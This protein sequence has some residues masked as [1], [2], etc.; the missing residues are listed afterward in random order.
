M[1]RCCV[2]GCNNSEKS[3]NHSFLSFPNKEKNLKVYLDIPFENVDSSQE[4][5]ESGIG[6]QCEMGQNILR[7]ILNKSV[8]EGTSQIL[9]STFD[10]YYFS[11]SDDNDES[12]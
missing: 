1:P 6:I 2:Y 7:S 3:G 9:D 5:V 10:P 12:D 8:P 11:E 4:Y